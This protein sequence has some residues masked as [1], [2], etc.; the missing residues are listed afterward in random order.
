MNLI[1]EI[2]YRVARAASGSGGWATQTT[3]YYHSL[4]TADEKEII[5]YHWH[6]GHGSGFPHP[7]MHLGAGIGADLGLLDKAH[8]PTGEIRLEDL[9]HFA[10]RELGAEPQ[11][12]G[13]PEILAAQRPEHNPR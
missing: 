11:R 2:R 7:H 8:I 1:A 13:W 4:E 3:A 9:L 10:I 12:E 6:P 5:S